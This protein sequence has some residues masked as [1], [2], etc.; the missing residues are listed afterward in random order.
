MRLAQRDQEIQT[1][2]PDGP[3]AAL[4]GRIRPWGSEWDSEPSHPYR[5]QRDHQWP[6]VDPNNKPIGVIICKHFLELLEGPGGS[7][8]TGDVEVDEPS[9][10]HPHHHT[11]I[12][13]M[14]RSGD[15]DEELARGGLARVPDL[16]RGMI[17]AWMDDMAASDLAINTL[18]CR[19]ATLSSFCTWLVKR[20]LLPANPVAQM[21]RPPHERVPPPVP[22][23]AIMHALIQ[24]AKERGRPRDVALFL[25]L[26]FTGMRREAMATLRVGHLDSTWGPRG[27]CTK[28]GKLRDVPLPAVV[29]RF[30]HVYV[31]GVLTAEL[32]KV[33]PETPLFW[34]SW[35]R[36]AVGKMRAPMTG[37]NIWRLCKVYGRRIGHPKPGACNFKKNKLVALSGFEPEIGHWSFAP[38]NSRIPS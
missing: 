33:T 4:A 8:M 11:D 7:G 13:N 32:G 5:P 17:Q 34:S 18:R 15:G 36:R 12:Q 30:L 16:N 37:K 6:G 19:Q 2:L 35:G 14:E 20:N 31:Q 29:M 9:A 22:A 21:D 27:V 38:E 28:G 1:L 3:D 23:P 26:R 24:A 10:P 25:L